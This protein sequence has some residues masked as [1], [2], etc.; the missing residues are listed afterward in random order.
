MLP[1][2]QTPQQQAIWNENSSLN[3]QGLLPY[4]VA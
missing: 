3:S 4:T 2:Q 1:D